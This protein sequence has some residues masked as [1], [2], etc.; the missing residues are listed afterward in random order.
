MEAL[1]LRKG[2]F[3][4]RIGCCCEGVFFIKK[5]FFVAERSLGKKSFLDPQMKGSSMKRPQMKSSRFSNDRSS[6]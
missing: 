4:G 1:D 3:I 5:F 2:L 6:F